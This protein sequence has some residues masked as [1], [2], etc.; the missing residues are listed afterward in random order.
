MLGSLELSVAQLWFPFSAK[1]LYTY[2]S[3]CAHTH[4]ALGDHS[5]GRLCFVSA[6]KACSH[7]LN[8]VTSLP[9]FHSQILVVMS[10]RD[11]SPPHDVSLL[12]VLLLWRPP[13]SA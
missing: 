2:W 8:C 12:T 7:F 11:F 9:V 10:T 5:K 6:E 1:G 13:S 3:A 4:T